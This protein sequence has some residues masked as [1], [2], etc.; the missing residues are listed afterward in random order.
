MGINDFRKFEFKDKDSAE[1]IRIGTNNIDD[2]IHN[3]LITVSVINMLDLE[4]PIKV[5]KLVIS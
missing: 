2:S 1:I 5:K 4:E 3:L